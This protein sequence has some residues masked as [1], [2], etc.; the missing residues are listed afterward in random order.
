MEDTR[1]K[2]AQLDL[3]QIDPD[4]YLGKA[5]I[6]E[7]IQKIK[8]TSQTKVVMEKLGEDDKPKGTHYVGSIAAHV[9]LRPK[10]GGTFDIEIHS[11]NCLR[12][13]SAWMVN[14]ILR[15]M[16]FSVAR[17][18]GWEFTKKQKTEIKEL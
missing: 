6:E 4:D 16:C 15:H 9:Y 10:L 3:S 13:E 7:S 12:T 11:S 1:N 8:G 18:Y 5:K 14:K 17:D 2:K